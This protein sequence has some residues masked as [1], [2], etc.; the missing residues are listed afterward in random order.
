MKAIIKFF[1]DIRYF[2]TC[3][4]LDKCIYSSKKLLAFIFSFVIIYLVIFTDKSVIDLLVFV[5][6]LLGLRSY[7]TSKNQDT[8]YINKEENKG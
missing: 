3:L 8:S 2:L 7:D 4:L 1:S 5:T 6:V